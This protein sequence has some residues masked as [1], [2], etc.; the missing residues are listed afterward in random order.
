MM[1]KKKL[2]NCNQ[3]LSSWFLRKEASVECFEGKS[4]MIQ[5]QLNKKNSDTNIILTK[6]DILLRVKIA[7]LVGNSFAISITSFE[8]LLK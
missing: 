1:Y 5:L 3:C 8:A 6:K 7:N 4:V 2:K